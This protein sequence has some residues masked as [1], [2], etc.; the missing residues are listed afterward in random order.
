L[1]DG[2]SSGIDI[3]FEGTMEDDRGRRG[4]IAQ[5]I[6]EDLQTHG[7]TERVQQ[8]LNAYPELAC[9]VLELQYPSKV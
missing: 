5:F 9:L 2:F 6:H 8:K 7:M 4:T 1:D 3:A